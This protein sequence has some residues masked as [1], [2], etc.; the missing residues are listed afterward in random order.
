VIWVRE[1]VCPGRVVR[2]AMG[3]GGDLEKLTALELR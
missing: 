3:G 1:S 2:V